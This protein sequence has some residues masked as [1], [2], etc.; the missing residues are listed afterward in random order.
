MDGL[1]KELYDIVSDSLYEMTWRCNFPVH[2]NVGLWSFLEAFREFGVQ[3]EFDGKNASFSLDRTLRE[4]Q[5]IL[6]SSMHKDEIVRGWGWSP[7]G[8]PRAFY[9]SICIV[10][11]RMGEALKGNRDEENIWSDIR[12]GESKDVRAKFEEQVYEFFPKYQEHMLVPVSGAIPKLDE[13]KLFNRVLRDFPMDVYQ[14]AII[15]SRE[16]EC[17]PCA[18]TLLEIDDWSE[19]DDNYHPS[20]AVME[21]Y[22]LGHYLFALMKEKGYKT[23]Y[24]DD[25][26]LSVLV[27]RGYY[28]LRQGNLVFPCKDNR[29]GVK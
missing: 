18:E 9:D 20:V 8:S 10:Y 6:Q 16:V 5:V 1:V 26:P 13:P 28:A 7:L 17:T 3:I 27:A 19:F 2:P 24:D 22:F 4:R 23:G 29:C 14:Q 21:E 12:N 25:E 11:D 15:R